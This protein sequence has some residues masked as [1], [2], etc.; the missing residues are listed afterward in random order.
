M[1]LEIILI[2]LYQNKNGILFRDIGL[3]L[4]AFMVG[5]TLGSFLVNKLFMM[6][7]NQ[8]RSS[9]W[10]GIILVIGFSLLNILVYFSIQA[11]LMSSLPIISVAL[12]LDG[13]FVSGIFAFT[14]LNR[15]ENQQVVVTQLYTADLIGGCIGS[16]IASLILI[17]VYGF[18]FSL[19][20]MMVLS[21]CCLIFVL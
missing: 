17:P 5:L 6:M 14:S 4:M 3:L 13:M 21:V 20:L 1:T 19:I 15:V 9:I 10:L 11:D 16:L 2:L 7:K 12:L 18:F 8:I